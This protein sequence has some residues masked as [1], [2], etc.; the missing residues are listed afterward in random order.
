MRGVPPGGSEYG[1]GQKNRITRLSLF[2]AAVPWPSVNLRFS[3]GLSRNGGDGCSDKACD[4]N[5]SKT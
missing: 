3:P 4:V 2:S 1:S 5:S